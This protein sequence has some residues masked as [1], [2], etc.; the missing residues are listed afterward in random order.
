MA[1]HRTDGNIVG[2]LS[3]SNGVKSFNGKPQ[4]TAFLT[5]G[6]GQETRAERV[7]SGDPRR[8]RDPRR[9]FLNALRTANAEIRPFALIRIP[10]SLV[11]WFCRHKDD[12]RA[13]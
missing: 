9:E 13:D 3:H 11:L 2:R 4:A 6:R 12:R 5:W 10:A 8:A 1:A 7:G